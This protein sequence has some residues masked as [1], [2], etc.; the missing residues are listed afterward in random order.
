MDKIAR[1]F[2]NKEVIA[3]SFAL[4]VTGFVFAQEKADALQLY[5]NGQYAD[6]IAVCQQELVA[7]PDNLDSYVVMCWALVKNRQYAEAEQWANAGL[8]INAYDHRLVE[9]LGEAKF[10]LGKNRESLD[11]LERYISYAPNGA[12]VGSAYYFMGEI[13][14]RQGRYQHADISLTMAVRLEPLLDYWWMRL[15]YAREMAGS[16]RSAVVAYEKSL[17]LNAGQADAAR[18]RDRAQAHL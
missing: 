16:Y 5:Y 10:Y 7:N 14:I 9:I 8:R 3:F 15:G 11:L 1:F 6:A 13:Y 18:G 2:T 4:M 12:R 17:S